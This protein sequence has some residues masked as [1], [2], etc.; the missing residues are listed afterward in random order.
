MRWG[1]AFSRFPM[2][3]CSL[4]GLW[5]LSVCA[6]TIWDSA[7]DNKPVAEL[8][9][10]EEAELAW[11]A[12]GPCVKAAT[13][14]RFIRSDTVT[15]LK[16]ARRYLNIIVSVARKKQNEVPP[17]LYEMN[18]H[19][20]HGS[21]QGCMQTAQNIYNPPPPEEG[22]ETPEE[23]G[24]APA[25]DAKSDPAPQ[26]SKDEAPAEKKPAEQAEKK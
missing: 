14:S 4:I 20:T 5:P 19:A 8:E 24:E 18:D 2:L 7:E 21:P 16:A 12:E 13:L 22:E 9:A 17:W 10:M 25:T 26:E 11:E 6:G 23:T 1:S 3:L 15:Q